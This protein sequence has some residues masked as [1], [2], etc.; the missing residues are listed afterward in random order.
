MIRLH[1][2]AAYHR[3]VSPFFTARFSDDAVRSC[4]SAVGMILSLCV[5]V[6]HYD[7]IDKLGPPF[8]YTLWVAGRV[9]LVHG[10]TFCHSVDDEKIRILIKALGCMGTY[11]PVADR[12]HQL[13]VRVYNDYRHSEQISAEFRRRVMPR[14]VK[15]MVDMTKN[16]YDLN[17]GIASLSMDEPDISRIPGNDYLS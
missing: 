7:I 9:L 13:L 1:S 3:P 4:V 12:Y 6:V 17:F 14:T 16:A 11:W 10:S 5:H 15:R 2:S 8:A